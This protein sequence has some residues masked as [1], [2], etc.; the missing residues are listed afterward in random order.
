M[1]PPWMPEGEKESALRRPAATWGVMRFARTGGQDGPHGGQE[2]SNG[3]HEARDGRDLARERSHFADR[4][5][6]RG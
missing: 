3:F 5:R 4:D 1:D 6:G 2:G